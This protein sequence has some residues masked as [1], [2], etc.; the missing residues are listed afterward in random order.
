MPVFRLREVSLCDDYYDND[1]DDGDDNVSLLK[2]IWTW[3]CESFEVVRVVSRFMTFCIQ[4]RVVWYICPKTQ[5][6]LYKKTII[7]KSSCILVWTRI[8]FWK[9]LWLLHQINASQ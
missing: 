3:A 5:G 1:N 6:D 9:I 7:L 4:R 2:Q 8:Q